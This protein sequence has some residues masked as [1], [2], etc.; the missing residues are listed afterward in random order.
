[1]RAAAAVLCVATFLGCGGR[2]D[3]GPAWPKR[4]DAEVD[5][6]ESL[7]PRTKSALAASET[8]AEKKDADAKP[9]VK[10][11][12]KSDEDEKPDDTKPAAATP[13]TTAPEDIIIIDD[14]VIEIED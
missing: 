10:A 6:G 3:R 2:S 9:E 1:M 12:E 5:G 7:A 8:K 11:A 4:A 14:I 13:T